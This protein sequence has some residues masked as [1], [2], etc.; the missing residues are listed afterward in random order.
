MSKVLVAMSGGVDSSVTAYLLKKAGHECMGCTMKLYDAN[1]IGSESDD[2]SNCVS[3]TSKTCCSLSDVEDARS[4]ALRLGM[5]YQVFN[6]KE[7]FKEHVIDPFVKSYLRAETPNPCI[8]CNRHLKF[9]KLLTQAKI[10][11]FD[12]IATGHYARIEFE[13]GYYKLKKALDPSK[14][15]SYVLYSLRQ[16]QLA[17]IHFPL[18]AMTKSE[19]RNIAEAQGFINAKKHD[20]QDICF[21]P[22]GDYS[23][24]IERYLAVTHSGHEATGAANVTAG[25][26]SAVIARPQAL[27]PGNFV[28]KNGNFIAKHK[29]I[30][31]YTIGQRRGL[32]VP[33]ASR[34]YVISVNPNT[35]EVVL[36]SNDDLFKREVRVKEFHWIKGDDIPAEFRCK[37]KIRYKHTEQPCT[38]TYHGGF[39]NE[40]S[41]HDGFADEASGRGGFA[42]EAS[43]HGEGSYATIMFDEPQRAITPGQTA[44]LYDGDTVLGG[45]IIY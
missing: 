15:Q 43:G 19:A 29:G 24:M 37:A 22:D 31:H 11:G 39:A 34:L 9:G 17:H 30:I 6:Y 35:S 26:D 38:V 7:A 28:D 23:G 20:S 10:L 16:E 5:K 4:V 14:D 12:D 32:G 42:D 40:T 8:E 44:V 41:G 2:S 45:G 18:G 36:G 3:C 33:A 27:Q 21:V 13:D 25:S 1:E